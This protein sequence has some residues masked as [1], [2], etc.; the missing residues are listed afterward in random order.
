MEKKKKTEIKTK[1]N[2]DRKK[3]GKSQRG[4]KR[5]IKIFLINFY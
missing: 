1:K 3:N 2:R 4:T 5:E